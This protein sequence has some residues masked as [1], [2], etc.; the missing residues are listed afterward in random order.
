MTANAV[1]RA[2]INGVIK[3]EANAVLAAMGLTPSDAFRI[4]TTKVA[5]EKALP[6][7]PLIPNEETIAAM[8]GA[9]KEKLKSLTSMEDLMADLKADLKV[10]D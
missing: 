1:V 6:F 10:N 5:I 7:E 3:Q 4:M 9:R 2:R 8:K